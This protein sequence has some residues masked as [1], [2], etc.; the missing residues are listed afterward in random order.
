MKIKVKINMEI[1]YAV[2]YKKIPLNLKYK[3][4]A[5]ERCAKKTNN[6]FGSIEFNST[7]IK[8]NILP[9][10]SKYF[11]LLKYKNTNER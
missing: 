7:C 8:E 10:Y 5:Y 3:I 1:N 4:K 9:K 2:L 11:I 6:I